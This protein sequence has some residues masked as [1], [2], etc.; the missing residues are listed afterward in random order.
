MMP[1]LDS[2]TVTFQGA[3]QPDGLYEFTSHAGDVNVGVAGG[4]GFE[5]RAVGL[6]PTVAEYGG[7][8]VGRSWMQALVLSGAIAGVGGINFVLGYKHYFEL[9][10]SD[11]VGFIGIAVALLAKNNP[12]GIVAASLFFGFLE[13]GGLTVNTLVPKELINIL[14]AVIIILLIALEIVMG[15]LRH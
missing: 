3:L 6:Q 13:Y 12:G 1:A 11:G 10:F 7:V 14:Q 5:L 15:L 2:G 4:A 8:P 9:G